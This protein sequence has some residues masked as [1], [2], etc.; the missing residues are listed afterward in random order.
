MRSTRNEW[1]STK[2]VSFKAYNLKLFILVN[3][4]KQTSSNTSNWKMKMNLIFWPISQTI[5]ASMTKK[6]KMRNEFFNIDWFLENYDEEEE[7]SNAKVEDEDVEVSFL[8]SELN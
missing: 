6:V 2:R 5:M 8:K 4:S 1:S 7:E 3:F